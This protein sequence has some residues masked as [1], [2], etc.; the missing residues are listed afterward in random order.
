V[1]NFK[2]S[3]LL[4]LITLLALVTPGCSK[5]KASTLPPAPEPAAE[6]TPRKEPP[7]SGVAVDSDG[8]GT[9]APG[10]FQPIYF[11]FDASDLLPEARQELEELATWLG[12]SPAATVR[13]EGHADDRG[14][15]EYNVA[16]GERR[17]RAIRDYLVRLGIASSRLSTISYG[18]ERPAA[19]GDDEAS[20]ARNRRGELVLSQ[21]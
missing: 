21:R 5:K 14:T 3:S 1:E 12:R 19:A 20:W 4:G 13:I 7:T 16:L 10:A 2:R 17:A 18:E 15:A 9:G 6:T 8:S 11:A